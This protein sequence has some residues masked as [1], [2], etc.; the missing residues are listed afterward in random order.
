MAVRMT[1]RTVIT[2]MS[3]VWV[4]VIIL[5][6]LTIWGEKGQ[7]KWALLTDDRDGEGFGE[8][9]TIAI[10]GGDNEFVITGGKVK[11]SKKKTRVVR[12]G[13]SITIDGDER[14]GRGL[15]FN[16]EGRGNDG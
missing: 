7:E 13:F 4:R 10:S 15:T 9:A 11:L 14:V 16:G 8:G 3:K 2:M 5:I 6:H 12:F 1:V